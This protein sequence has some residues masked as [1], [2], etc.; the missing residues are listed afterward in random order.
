MNPMHSAPSVSVVMSVFNGERFLREAIESILSQTFS[1]FEFIIVNDG[2]SDGTAAI[3]DSY[4]INDLRVHV[5]HQENRGAAES[6]NRG[7]SSARGKYIARMDADDIALNER[8]AQQIDFLEKHNEVGL[9]GGQ[10]QF[11]DPTGNTLFNWRYP[12]NDQEIR[13]LLFHG[14]AFAHPAV[15]MRKEI[16][17]IVGGYRKVFADTADYDLWL[18]IAGRCQVANLAEV[19]LKYRIHPGQV[20]CRKLREQCLSILAAQAFASLRGDGIPEPVV[21]ADRFTPEVLIRLGVNRAAQERAEVGHYLTWIGLMSQSSQD[22]GVVRLVD[23]LIEL[24]R[25]SPMDRSAL[26]N[27]ILSAAR[28]HYRRGRPLPALVYLGRAILTRPIIA[29]RPLKRA[30][31]SLSRRF[32]TGTEGP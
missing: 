21:S 8:L 25:S 27:A 6:W 1:D 24:S 5:Y 13:S 12:L 10:L 17:N 18:R 30:V 15:V 26:S 4:A 9:L 29:G 19:V 7:C 11:I 23:E 14:N 20:S 32:Q 31:S 16:F 22:D 28:S 3:L 2:S